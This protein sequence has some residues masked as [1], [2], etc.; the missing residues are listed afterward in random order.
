MN[1]TLLISN[2]GR[3]RRLTL[4]RPDKRNALDAAL[5]RK[6]LDAVREAASDRAVGA[7]LLD[8]N[9]KDFC[10]GMDL[11]EVLETDP[12]EMLRLH[13]ELF[14]IGAR[15]RK[16]MV[17][18][19]QGAAL[20]GG[21]GLALNAHIVIASVGATFGLTEVRVGLWPYV[22]FPVVAAAIG[23][24]KATELALTARIVD[25]EEACRLG[26]VDVVVESGVLRERA[27]GIALEMAEA[28]ATVVEKGLSFVR[29]L[30]GARAAAAMKTART[31]RREAQNSA[32]FRAGVLAF[33]Q[34]RKPEWPS[35]GS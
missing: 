28:S 21:L 35:H 24:R 3:L 10:S 14:S 33:R 2:Q 6:L 12:D 30:L 29:Q 20:A 5:C 8:A 34:K 1:E 13:Q 15:L 7:I 9:G 16:P 22:I 18:A 27:E 17:S 25:V 23:H 19:V 32:E 11:A 31:F 4:N 26:I